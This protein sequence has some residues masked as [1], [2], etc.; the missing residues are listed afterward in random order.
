MLFP[1][2]D[3]RCWV[4]GLKNLL[5]QYPPFLGPPSP[6]PRRPQ[7]PPPATYFTSCPLALPM[8]LLGTYPHPQTPPFESYPRDLWALSC[9]NLNPCPPHPDQQN[10]ASESSGK[11]GLQLCLCFCLTV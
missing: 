6:P 7:R 11:L 1:R 10:L 9:L 5:P 8:D 2:E 3:S 4:E